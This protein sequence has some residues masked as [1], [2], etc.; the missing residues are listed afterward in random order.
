M[1][2]LDFTLSLNPIKEAKIA[3]SIKNNSEKD[4]F[5]SKD[6]IMLDGFKNDK[7]HIFDQEGQKIPYIGRYVK[8]YPEFVLIKAHSSLDN[9]LS[10]HNA[11][12][13]SKVG[14]Y[15]ASYITQIKCCSSEE[16]I[17]CSP[18]ESIQAETSIEISNLNFLE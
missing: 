1:K 18:L 16:A 11:Y 15:S 5:I 7:F 14:S 2:M 3:L 12:Q 17:D 13:F 6:A 4:C 8:Y 10:L 9:E